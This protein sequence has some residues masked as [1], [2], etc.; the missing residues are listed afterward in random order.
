[1]RAGNPRIEALLAGFAEAERQEL[2][3]TRRDLHRHP[4]LA[5]EEHRTADRISGRLERMGLPLR[6]G[7]GRTG[8]VSDPGPPGTPDSA[9]CRHGRPSADRRDGTALCVGDTRRD[10]RVRARRARRD[11]S[12]RGRAPGG[13]PRGRTFPAPL[14]ARRGGSGR[15]GGVRGGRRARRRYGGLRTAPLESAS[16]GNGRRQPGSAHGRGGRVLDRRGGAGRA[17]R[18]SPRDVRHHPRRRPH[19]RGAPGGRRSG[20]LAPRLRGRHRRIDSRGGRLQRD[21]GVGAPDRDGALLHGGDGPGAAR[22]DRRGSSRARRP[23]RGSGRAS[24]TAASTARPSTTP[25]WRRS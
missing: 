22:E 25:G 5:F 21:S 17:W 1:M 7:V 18:R 11:R 2:V 8:V 16:P 9:A 24:T 14:P 6:S 3:E 12:G 20:D 15:S 4:E 10:A 23:P 13:G 19:R